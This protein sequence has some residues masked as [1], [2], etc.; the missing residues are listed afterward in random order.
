MN[1]SFDR[2]TDPQRGQDFPIQQ[3]PGIPAEVQL[4]LSQCG[5]E[6]TLQL[7]RKTPDAQRRQ[8][9]ARSLNLRDQQISKW[10]AMADLARIP[11]IGT[12]YCG[13]L[14]HSGIYSLRQLA[15]ADAGRLHRHILRFQVSLLQSKDR[16]P[17]LAD[18]VQWIQVAKR[19]N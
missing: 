8:A 9:F 14:L 17:P 13:L 12:Q 15:Q 19:M 7:W 5:I 2:A 11:G 6:T 4:R 3:L 10:S 18:V 16:C 1:P